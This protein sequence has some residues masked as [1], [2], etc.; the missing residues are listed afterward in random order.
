VD[1]CTLVFK[2]AV[3][4]SVSQVKHGVFRRRVGSGWLK[5]SHSNGLCPIIQFQDTRIIWEAIELKLHPDNMNGKG[6]SLSKAW[7]PPLLQILKKQR[8]DPLSKKSDLVLTIQN[9]PF[10]E[11][12][13]LQ[14]H[15]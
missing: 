6:F 2:R 5:L 12:H 9:Q 10:S 1:W 4:E 11:Q 7:K 13:P 3:A 14:L 8:K 15:L